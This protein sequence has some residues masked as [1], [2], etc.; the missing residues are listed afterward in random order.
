MERVNV[1]PINA[2]HMKIDA[3]SGTKM[4]LQSYFSFRPT[5]YQFVPAYKNRVWDGWVRL[6]SPLRPVLYVGLLPYLTKFCE[7]RGYE[8]NVGGD[9]YAEENVPDNYGYEIAEEIGC[10]FQPRDYQN[11]YV[12]NAIRKNRSLSLSPTSSG[13]SLIIYLIQQHYY[14][15]YGHRTLIIVPTISLV[16]QM[17]GDFIDYGCTDEIYKIQGGVDKNTDSPI[18]ISTW[19]SLIKQPKDWFDQFRVV[20]GDEAHQFQAKS[21]QKIM[22]ALVNCQY[23]HG[24]TGTL[25]SD[26]SKTHRLVLEGCFGEV[27]RYVTTKDLMD[28]GTV[29]DFKVK[30]IVLGYEDG[31]KKEFRKAFKKIAEPSKKYPAEREFLINNHKRNIFI[32][33]LLWSLEGQ[34]NLVLF[35][36][37]EK[38]GKVLEPLLRKD[39]RQLHFIYG[40]TKG[41]ERERIRNLVE[42]DPIKQH[43]ILASYGVF[44]TG[45]NLKK[46]DNVIFA[47][48][49]KSEIKVLQ[50]I[51]RALRKGNDA[52][53][54]TLYD[55]TDDLSHGSFENYT[56]K[57]FKKR[58]E[59]YGSEQ[60]AF[61][62]Y[63]VNI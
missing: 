2:V 55:I 28:S 57:H 27:K 31:I 48:G 50:S 34:N 45:V 44:S 51:G 61:K 56:L 21:L 7:D 25:K 1:E 10:K 11:E 26:E 20:L 8:L 41:D 46:L 35:D 16:H 5:G 30:A 19:Q 63:N 14:Q 4:E 42:N 12:V 3:D 18:V 29:A 59:I 22:D 58:I 32:R 54:A 15:A 47:S 53:K 39:D 17:A 9:M 23:R 62:I 37:V 24:F 40:G 52:D 60:F 36:L 33:N 6:F 49:S 38:H 43:D 13:K